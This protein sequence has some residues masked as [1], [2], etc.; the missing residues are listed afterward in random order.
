LFGD[1][2]NGDAVG[3]T[4]GEDKEGYRGCDSWGVVVVV[5][6]LFILT[7]KALI[8]ANYFVGISW[9]S[10]FGSDRGLIYRNLVV[11]FSFLEDN[12]E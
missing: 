11:A 4:L 9:Y 6:V 8:D 5:V 2:E 3:D 12:I 10:A 7:R 1:E